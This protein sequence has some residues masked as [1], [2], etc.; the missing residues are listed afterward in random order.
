MATDNWVKN[1]SWQVGDKCLVHDPKDGT[2]QEATIQRLSTSHDED[3][4]A[5]VVLSNQRNDEQEE[6]VVP[7][8]KIIRAGLNHWTQEK[9]MFPSSI[10]DPQSC[11]ALELNDA[12]G[13]KVPYTINRYLRNYQREGVRF[14]YNNYIRSSGCILG[15]DMGLG[16]TV[17]VIAFLS[18]V[19]HKT[20]TWVD[21]QK[22]RPQFLQSQFTSWQNKPNKVF[23]IVA[24][25]SVLYNWKDELDTWG[26]FQSVVVHGLKKE[27]EFARIRKGRTE[28]A[29]TTYETL[30]LCLDEFNAIDWSAVVVD[31]AH[32]IKNPNSQI[33]QAMKDLKCEVRIGLTGTIFQNNLEELWCVMDWAIPGCLGSLGLFKTHYSYL[34]EQAQRH[35]ATKRALATGRKTAKALARKISHWFLRRTKALIKEQLPKKDDR[36]VFCSLTEFQQMVYQ[37][38][39]DTEDVTLL[40]RASEKCSCQSGRARRSCCYSTNSEGLKVKHLYFIYLAILRK[41]SNNVALLKSTAG[42]SKS[43]EKYVGAICSK[44]FQKF[45]DFVRRCKDESFEALSDPMYSGKMKVLEKLLKYYLQRRDKVLLFSLSTKLLDV[46]ESYCMAQ[47]LDYSRL[48]GTTKAKDR[49]QIVKEFNSSSHVN[50]CLV[51]TMAGGLGLNFVGANVVV[52][53]D[54]TWNPSSDL[55]AIDRAYRI[56]QCRDVTVLRLISLGTVEE[57]IYLRQLYKQ[58]LQCT[59]LG[60]ESSRRYFEAV[61]GNFKGELFGIKNLFRLQTQGTCLTQKILEREGRLEAGITTTSVYTGEGPTEEGVSGSGNSR[62]RPDDKPANERR[63]ALQVPEGVLDFSSGSEEDE[64]EFLKNAV[65]TKRGGN[66]AT[67]PM[68]LLQHGFSKLLER[69]NGKAELIEDES[70]PSESSEEDLEDQGKT[71][72]SIPCNPDNHAR[73][74]KLQRKTAD[75]SSSSDSG[76]RNEGRNDKT[77]HHWKRWTKEGRTGGEEGEKKSS[78]NNSRHGDFSRPVQKSYHAEVYSDESEDLDTEITTR[79]K[80]STSGSKQRAD[81]NKKRQHVSIKDRS[82]SSEDVEMFTSSEEEHTPSKKGKRARCHVTSVQT[83]KSGPSS[84]C[85][86]SPTSGRRAGAIDSVLGRVQE[87]KYTHSNQRVV[88]GSRAEELI[89][90]AA[91]RDVFERK[92]HSQLPANHLLDN[93]ESLSASPANRPCPSAVRSQKPSADHPVIFTKTSV[94]HTRHTTFIVGETPQAIRRQQLEE[95]AV[96]FQFPSVH[97]FAAELLRRDPGQRV[98][99][100]RQYYTSLDRPGLSTVTDNFP[101]PDS[102]R[103]TSSTST[104]IAAMET[105]ADTRTLQNCCQLAQRTPKYTRRNPKSRPGTP[106]NSVTSS[107]KKPRKPQTGAEEPHKSEK[108]SRKN[109]LGAPSDVPSVQSECQEEMVCRT[110]EHRRTKR[111]SVSGS[112]ASRA[113]GGVGSDQASSSGLGSAEA[114]RDGRSSADLS[115]DTSAMLSKPTAQEHRQEPKSSTGTSENVQGQRENVESPNTPRQNT[116]TSLHSSFLTDLIG[117]TSIL[118]DLLKPKSRSAQRTPTCSSV[119][120]P[121]TPTPGRNFS[122]DSKTEQTRSKGSRKDFWDILSEGNEESI[123]RLTDPAEVRRVCINTNFA[124]GSRSGETEGKSLWKTN[125]KFLW[126]K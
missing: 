15:D 55:Q 32:R 94:H 42:T 20:G 6:E 26:H 126:K 104:I 88:G 9:P 74:P 1:D 30:R 98:T 71:A 61:H 109:S 43:Q 49:V 107:Q 63:E 62:V 56:G 12:D 64:C 68:S 5:W 103:S 24:P 102:T 16:K 48:D 54:P 19:L 65:D 85:Q 50:L 11:V 108:V 14:I 36:V 17:Q 95:M 123:N 45:P 33:T 41:V 67:E 92:M 52:L 83:K 76:G 87:V 8:S 2:L 118:D 100:L 69:V 66:A 47:G 22:N 31:E 27:E 34:I 106:Q 72:S 121:A 116:P 21:V 3:T 39:L 13:D 79:Q 70:C 53:F 73:C 38:V 78:P 122:T 51:S 28:I 101:Q 115:H 125:E 105:H 119:R 81:C 112:G 84:K 117:D 37:T 35:S 59:V 93:A 111:A 29:L 91:E 18:A 75:I 77:R 7:V 44:V 4:M 110:R 120:Y 90:R 57:I 97:Q 80:E 10:T 114:D 40:L 23:L 46:L 58:Q 113:G 124:A 89:S 86:P 60:K 25:L 82:K 96:K 99:W